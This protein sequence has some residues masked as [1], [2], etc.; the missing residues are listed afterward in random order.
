MSTRRE[1]RKTVTILFCD[2]VHST[3]LAEGDPEAYRHTQERF[4][5]EMRAI[6]EGHG[7]TVEKFIGDEVMAVFGV[8]FAHEDDALR[9][10]RAAQ[11]MQ[12]AVTSLGLE[13]TIGI[14]TGEVLAAD[15]SGGHSFVS[16]E[17]VIV[18]K[19][20]EQGAEPGEIVIGKATFPLISHAVSAGPLERIPVKG[21]SEDVGR[22]LVEE[23]DREA[24]AFARRLHTPIVGRTE[25]LGLLQAA[26]ERAVDGNACR[27]FTILG[28]A[29][30]GKSR[31]AAEL[32]STV[33]ERATAAFGRCLP[34][35]EGITYWPL[36]EVARALE[37][38]V[39]GLALAAELPAEETFPAVR[40]AFEEAAHRR[41]LLL[42]F[43]DLHWAEPTFLDLVEYVAS[44]S[45]DAP[46]FIL[47]LARP[48]LVE[49]RPTW[50][51]PRANADAV[52]LEP[53]SGDEI[54]SLLGGLSL[55]ASLQKR[56]TQAAEGNPLFAEQMAAMASETAHEDLPIP[57]SLQ[58]LL[59]ERLDR[60]TREERDAIER[61]AVV[62]RDFPV[63]ALASL[64]DTEERASLTGTLMSLVRKGLIEPSA[65]SRDEDRFTFQHVLVRDAAYESMPK[66]LRADL[67][68][69][70]ADA[71]AE[72]AGDELVGYHLEQAYRARAAVAPT[73][74]S[75]DE[76]A[77]GGARRLSSAGRRAAGREDIPAALNLF[78]RAAVLL[79][80]GRDDALRASILADIGSL[81]MMGGRFEEVAGALDEAARLAAAEG[82]RSTELRVRIER[83]FLDVFL[84]ADTT[85]AS[86]DHIRRSV[87]PELEELE[88]DLGLAKAWHLLSEP[89]V[90]SCEWAKRCEF[91]DRALT[92]ARRTGDRRLVSSV[93]GQLCVALLFG[94]TPADAAVQRCEDLLEEAPLGTL[95]TL[96]A[97]NAMRGEF[98]VA[99]EQWAEAAQRYEELGLR[100]RRA[101]RS[102]IGAQVELLAGDPEAAVR[103]LEF[104]EAEL[105][106]MG[107]RGVRS[108]I[109]ASLADALYE[110]GRHDEAFAATERSEELVEPDDVATQVVWRLARAKVLADCG[111]LDAAE[112]LSTEAERLSGPT[113]FPDVQARAHISRSRVLSL[114]G[115]E[116]EARACLD[117]AVEIYEQ[118]GNV[119]A[120][121]RTAKLLTV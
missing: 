78:E 70:L 117:R 4:F 43:E 75:L 109:A 91:L 34:Y 32:V 96:A 44:S 9:A 97:L 71:F 1:A 60:L 62:G 55:S 90:V 24:P 93:S 69:R 115:R 19:R 84:D 65:R 8:P 88:D 7:G 11:E 66:S 49:R 106:A 56:I 114:T 118:K 64:A 110:A 26:F 42:C 2:L 39:I 31:L 52:A 45:R 116:D 37:E 58:G 5:Q 6:V 79:A 98:A 38:D 3:G 72:T 10:V 77:V 112:A 15:P 99:R 53:L 59:T 20:L 12:N 111:E 36:A 120:T 95:S 81:L 73:D 47:I 107:E 100:F 103:E 74:P 85:A 18:A 23:V 89:Y 108:T 28:P 119:V 48:E 54:Q 30:I 105:E 86:I 46:I 82:E 27:L 22:H 16:G 68:E 29:G 17:P 50:I 51:T 33:G 102:L 94:P 76:L 21:K 121:E 14:N 113:E 80:D 61:A 63:S 67:H 13:A 40:R 104:G 41:P 101:A 92:H 35:G 83:A 57:G 25:E 87:V